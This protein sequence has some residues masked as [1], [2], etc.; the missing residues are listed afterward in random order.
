M[1]EEL[2]ESELTPEEALKV[3]YESEAI[4]RQEYIQ[5]LVHL[6]RGELYRATAWRMRLDTTTNWAI[7]TTAGLLSFSF[8]GQDHGH[9]VLLLGT[10]LIFTLLGYEARRFRFFDV[11]RYRVRMMEENFY[12]PILRRDPIS[13]DLHW[14][15]RVATDLLEP[16]FKLGFRAAIRARF[17][18][19]YWVIFIV[20]VGAWCLKVTQ[21]PL[22]AS[23]W[24][25][26]KLNLS[27]GGTPWWVPVSFFGAVVC[28]LLA[29]FLFFP[30]SQESET[31]YWREHDARRD[32]S[33]LDA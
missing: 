3:D 21:D 13:P 22:P 9:W 17:T 26:L 18:R 28:T 1:S 30:R 6:Y 33:S 14:G 10:L 29:I 24:E 32:V 25:Q 19:N 27:T 2:P 12:G 23:N 4:S 15:D 7:L 31:A 11:W 20:I 8:S 5:A 16:H